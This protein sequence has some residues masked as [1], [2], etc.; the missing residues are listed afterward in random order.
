MSRPLLISTVAAVLTLSS[1]LLPASAGS[2]PDPDGLVGVAKARARGFDEIRLR[3]GTDFSRYS[4]VL[5]QPADVAFDPRWQRDTAA[6]GRMRGVSDADAARM[7]ATAREGFDKAFADAFAKSSYSSASA[8]AG[9]V[10]VVRAMVENIRVSAPETNQPGIT[11]SYASEAGSARLVVEI[12]DSL[13]NALLGRATDQRTIDESG[14][15]RMEFRTSASNQADFRRAFE[16]WSKR[17]V[18]ALDALRTAAPIP[19]S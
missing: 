10:L 7:L 11:R 15:G 3:P 19:A 4:R 18:E 16:A 5:I 13:T 17:S 8:P 12:R 2:A 1:A 9:D 6:D 14:F